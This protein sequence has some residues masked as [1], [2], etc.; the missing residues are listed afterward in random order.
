MARSSA[1]LAGRTALPKFAT[2]TP[3]TVALKAE[4]ET[5]LDEQPRGRLAPRGAV[6]KAGILLLLTILAYVALVLGTPS[7]TFGILECIAFGVLVAVL[8]FNV[9]HEAAHGNFSTR[10]WVNRALALSMDFAGVSASLYRIKHTVFHH[11][12]TNIDGVDGDVSEAPVLRMSTRQPRWAIHRYQWVYALPLYSLMTLSWVFFDDYFRLV[13]GKIG[14]ASFNRP[15][16]VRLLGILAL[17]FL[18]PLIAIAIPALFHPIRSVVA[19]YLIVQLV[20]ASILSLVF[21]VAHLFRGTA[22][23][24]D[25]VQLGE[26]WMIHQLKTTADFATRNRTVTFLLGGLN[27]QVEHHLFPNV[28]YAHYPAIQRIVRRSCSEFGIAYQEF[29]SL[30]AAVTSHFGLLRDLG[31]IDRPTETQAKLSEPEMSAPIRWLR[32]IWRCLHL[33][34][35]LLCLLLRKGDYR[36]IYT[37]FRYFMTHPSYRQSMRMLM[38]QPG[39]SDLV[40]SR[41]NAAGKVDLKTLGELPGGTLGKVF[42]EFMSRP[43]ITQIDQLPASR[44]TIDPEIDYIRARLRLV[45]DIHH[46]VTGFPDTEIGEMGISAFYVAQVRSPLNS[47]ILAVGLIKCT[48]KAPERLSELMETIVEGWEMGN[49]TR[50]LFGAKWEECFDLPLT[51]LQSRYLGGPPSRL[52]WTSSEKP[53]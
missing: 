34:H 8:G 44:E 33:A 32:N 48:V 6:I 35:G 11:N 50:G 9:M 46:V 47:M 20:L 17:K 15:R 36:V 24:E 21:Q 1:R 53:L 43:L 26:D 4:V 22:F 31:R 52:P 29:D 51:T 7:V 45:H 28:A 14:T 38:D 37:A 16:G 18:H 40:A 25:A 2:K 13:N 41:Y 42:A 39:F 27:F 3:F 23:P 19:G 5:Y 10:G 49:R 12:Y 30:T